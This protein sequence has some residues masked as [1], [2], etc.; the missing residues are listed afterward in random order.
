VNRYKTRQLITKGFNKQ[1]AWTFLKC[2]CIVAK[3]VF[4]ITLFTFGEIYNLKIYQVNMKNALLNG[5]LIEDAEV[6]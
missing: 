1:R 5:E 6:K 2:K 3:F 4:I